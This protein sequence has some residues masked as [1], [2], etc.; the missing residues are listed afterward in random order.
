M[1]FQNDLVQTDT[2]AQALGP[3]LAERIN[4]SLVSYAVTCQGNPA[5]EVGDMLTAVLR[6]GTVTARIQTAEYTY[7][8]Y[9]KTVYTLKGA[10]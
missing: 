2:Q 10:S 4:E 6:T 1:T 3:E 8:G 9:L 7:Q 5:L